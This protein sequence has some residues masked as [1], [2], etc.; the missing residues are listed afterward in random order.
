MFL[1][2]YLVRRLHLV[3][4]CFYR[5]K[6]SLMSVFKDESQN[7]P[8]PL[9][10]RINTAVREG[11]LLDSSLGSVCICFVLVQKTL[12]ISICLDFFFV[13]LNLGVHLFLEYALSR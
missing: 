12:R 4:V 13:F 3:I 2:I 9:Y 11:D 10:I 5:K 1:L 8:L 6:F 7:Y